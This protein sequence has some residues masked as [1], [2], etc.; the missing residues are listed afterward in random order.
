MAETRWLVVAYLDDDGVV[1]PT[2]FPFPLI[3]KDASPRII[4]MIE[5][6]AERHGL[7]L[8]RQ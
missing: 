8:E 5:R 2:D 7:T 3:L 6:A 4:E 1:K